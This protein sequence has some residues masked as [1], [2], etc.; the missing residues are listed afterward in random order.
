[1]E[2]A[3]CETVADL[4]NSFGRLQNFSDRLPANFL[5]GVKW[6]ITHILGV[7][8]LT[9]YIAIDNVGEVLALDSVFNS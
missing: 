8:S 1:M 4:M 7:Y 6:N 3:G 9:E 2:E 5:I